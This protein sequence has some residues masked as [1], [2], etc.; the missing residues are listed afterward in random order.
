MTLILAV[1]GGNSKT[2]LALVDGKGSLLAAQRG[3]T[4]SHQ[5]AGWEEGFNRLESMA[6]GVIDGRADRPALSVFGL[7]GADTP[8]VSRRLLSGITKL[9]L[10]SKSIVV[11]DAVIALRAG[12]RSD[13]G[14]ALVCGAGINGFGRAP[15]GR[16]ARFAAL[17]GISGDWGGGGDLGEAALAAAVRARDGRGSPTSLSQ[18]VAQHFGVRAPSAVSIAIETGEIPWRRLDE[19]VPLVFAAAAAG[20]QIGR[21][22]ID[23]QSEELAAMTYG[24]ARRLGLLRREVDVVLSGGVF[25]GY[26]QGLLGDLTRRIKDRVPSARPI[27]IPAPPV[28]GAALIGLDQLSGGLVGKNAERRLQQALVAW[29]RSNYFT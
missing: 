19:L 29:D 12:T 24:L 20:D 15:D 14:I 16:T 25:K 28:L 7:A 23:R 18:S 2:D 1:D 22:L 3:P 26:D 13:C 8:A 6:R 27:R 4:V 9:E 10:S 11:N 21:G 17:G 5:M